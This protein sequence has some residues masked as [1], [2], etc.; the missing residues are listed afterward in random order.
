MEVQAAPTIHAQGAIEHT[1]ERPQAVAGLLQLEG[2]APTVQLQA[3]QLQ[4][5]QFR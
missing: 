4:C 5:L 1:L 2:L 3:V